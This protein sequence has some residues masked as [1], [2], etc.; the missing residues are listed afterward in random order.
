MNKFIITSYSS[1]VSSNY[2]QKMAYTWKIKF[3]FSILIDQKLWNKT[4]MVMKRTGD[5]LSYQG[6][7]P[8]YLPAPADSTNYDRRCAAVNHRP[9]I[10]GDFRSVKERIEEAI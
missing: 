3:V 5:R 9:V 10:H 7:I 6:L 2:S 4:L 1:L 8:N